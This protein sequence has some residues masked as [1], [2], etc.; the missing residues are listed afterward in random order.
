LDHPIEYAVRELA[1][2]TV[3]MQDKP[4][5]VIRVIVT[6]YLLHATVK[7]RKEFKALADEVEEERMSFSAGLSAGMAQAEIEHKL[8]AGPAKKRRKP[9]GGS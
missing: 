4:G 3:G 1:R 7:L 5:S 6:G 9:K 2:S 8:S